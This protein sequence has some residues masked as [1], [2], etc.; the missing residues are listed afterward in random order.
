VSPIDG[1]ARLSAARLLDEV[2][3]A[4]RGVVAPAIADPYPRAQAHMAAVILEYVSR[5]VE[6]RG[7]IDTEKAGALEALFRELPAL[8]DGTPLPGSDDPDREA[9]LCRV[10]E[11][12]YAER[13]RLGPTVFA[14]ANGRVRQTL[15]QLLDQELKVAGNEPV[16]RKPA[17]TR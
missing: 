10:I 11:W 9:R 14:A 2:I 15:R 3:A 5:Q 6:E 7:D 4:L 1:P 16:L 13:A 17:T 12:L 8:L